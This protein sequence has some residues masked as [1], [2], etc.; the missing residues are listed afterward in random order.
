MA[1]AL[2]GFALGGIWCSLVSQFRGKN[3]SMRKILSILLLAPLTSLA[4]P[5]ATTAPAAPAAPTAAEC[6]QALVEKV[7]GKPM[8]GPEQAGEDRSLGEGDLFSNGEGFRTGDKGSVDL[9]LCDGSVVRIGANTEVELEDVTTD[10]WDFL[11]TRGAVRVALSKS[12]K[13]GGPRVR[14]RSPTGAVGGRSG[15]FLVEVAG[16]APRATTLHTLRGEALLGPEEGWAA[17]HGLKEQS[18]PDRFIVVPAGQGA[19]IDSN[20]KG[21]TEPAKFERSKLLK[22]RQKGAASTLFSAGLR[23]MGAKEVQHAY[24]RAEDKRRKNLTPEQ[25]E[26]LE[27]AEGKS[28]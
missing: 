13:V 1:A 27:K 3:A 17:L 19:S 8:K 14:L 11:L 24:K 15:E 4:N 7:H 28:K 2:R 6:D 26:K 5:A 21:A 18:V 9:R 10:N 25:R 23:P 20:A 22:E 12:E 16:E